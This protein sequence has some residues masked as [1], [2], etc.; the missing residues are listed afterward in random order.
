[1]QL[2]TWRNSQHYGG[3]LRFA[4]A[5]SNNGSHGDNWLGS[6]FI[7]RSYWLKLHACAAT[8]IKIDN[9]QG[10]APNADNSIKIFF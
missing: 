2:I 1:M 9:A 7:F 6:Y 5:S 4:S 10:V 3:A 8:T